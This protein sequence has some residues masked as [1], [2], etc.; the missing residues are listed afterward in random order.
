[1]TIMRKTYTLIVMLA[2]LFVG[3]NS[4]KAQTVVQGDYTFGFY[5][6][7]NAKIV[8]YTGTDTEI[9]IP[10]TLTY[11]KEGVETTVNV[12]GFDANSFAGNTTIQ[13][14]HL[15][16]S[17]TYTLG[18][19]AFKGCTAL[20]T[21]NYAE[22]SGY[23][24]NTY[25]RADNYIILP[26]ATLNE[27]VFEGCTS[28][29]RVY[30]R[31]SLTNGIGARAFK[32]C[33]ALTW[34]NVSAACPTIGKSAFQG[35]T[36]LTTLLFGTTG[37]SALTEIA[38][39]VFMGCQFLKQVGATENLVS[40][41][42]VTKIG[43]SAFRGAW[44]MTTINIPAIETIGQSAFYNPYTDLS[45]SK[46]ETVIGCENLTSLGNYAFY[47]CAN[48]KT[49]GNTEGLIYLPKLSAAG[50]YTFQSCQAIEAVKMNQDGNKYS[51][52]YSGAFK[53]CI[54][55]TKVTT[56]NVYYI[57]ESAF[58]GDAQLIGIDN[59]DNPTQV[60]LLY[61]TEIQANA[62][63]GCSSITT[64]NI[65]SSTQTSFS[66]FGNQALKDCSNLESVTLNTLTPPTLGTDVF[67]GLKS[68]ARFYIN[69]NNS[70][71][72][73]SN[74]ANN[75]S[76]K[77]WFDGTNANYSL[78]AYVNKTKQYGTVSC[79]V[80]LHFNSSYTANI[81]KV[82]AADDSYSY[83]KAVSGKK[84]P[85]NTGAV[86]EMAANGD[87]FRT[88]AQ[89]KVLFDGS[90]SEADFEDNQLVANVTENL[91]FVGNEGNTWNLILNDGKF[92]KANDGTLAAGLAYLPV[93][94]EGGEAKELS[95]TTDEPTGIKTID[96]GEATVDNGA[97][98]TIDGTR[99]QGEPTMKGIYIKN[100]KKIVVK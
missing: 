61:T 99:L 49:I 84:L 13:K 21:L 82:V 29:K 4:V 75:D 52:F 5:S 65:G 23:G 68:D 10:A 12:T 62:F 93:T 2:M 98:Y 3:A 73:V 58:E 18:K 72:S 48:L 38:D 74:Y 26:Q 70:Y 79:D 1:M 16:N 51:Y 15:P 67:S 66:S 47:R 64:L 24:S 34:A 91:N 85:A 25:A 83:L 7:G 87:A 35:C 88:S 57:Y 55:L 42:N 56:K 28:I 8:A 60:R 22:S 100:G 71:K 36:N 59:N 27:G 44:T 39:S 90:A 33:T 20:N 41:P 95:L 37:V 77:V 11:D 40:F 6:S 92:V 46:L 89:A 86:I 9:T 53:D 31:P 19:E 14:I 80:P 81:H 69:P 32:G 76:W 45:A 54:S 94:F 17:G 63:N 97:W 50:Y 43:V 30:S 96:N 78:Y